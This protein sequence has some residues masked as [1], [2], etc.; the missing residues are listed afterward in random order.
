MR[1]IAMAGA[2]TLALTLGACAAK[3]PP[4]PPPLKLVTEAEPKAAASPAPPNQA[5]LLAEQ[6]TEVQEAVREHDKSGDWPKY[7]T[8]AYTLYPYDRGPEPV[9]DCGPL[10]TTDI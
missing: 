8:P 10:R 6:P 1:R 5:Q 3:Q 7:K 9:V 2:F 4:A